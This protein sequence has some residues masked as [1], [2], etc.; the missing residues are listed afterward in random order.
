MKYVFAFVC[1][2]ALI[3]PPIGASTV[4]FNS[5]HNTYYVGLDD[6]AN[7]DY[8]YND[9][10]FS[11]VSDRLLTLTADFGSGFLQSSEPLVYPPYA[12]P[13]NNLLE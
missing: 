3:T 5:A 13:S 2:T 8:D 4:A 1:L 11:L 9:L 12:G 10:I 7:G 6:T